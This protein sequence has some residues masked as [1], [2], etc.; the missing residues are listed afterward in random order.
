MHE[1]Y[2]VKEGCGTTV[3][4]DQGE[5]ERH[6]KLGWTDQPKDWLERKNAASKA[7]RAE[8]VKAEL[9][10]LTAEAA[11]LEGEEAVAMPSPKR[12]VKA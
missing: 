12:K 1:I 6:K 8:T 3:V 7:Q 5:Y 9:A 11:A 2:M 4:F 10:R